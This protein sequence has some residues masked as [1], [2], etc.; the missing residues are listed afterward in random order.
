MHRQIFHDYAFLM[1]VLVYF[2]NGQIAKIEES[3]KNT[4]E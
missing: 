1:L 2:Q 3:L 4:R